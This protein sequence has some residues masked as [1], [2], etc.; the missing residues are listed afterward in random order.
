MKAELLFGLS[1]F[2]LFVPLRCASGSPEENDHLRLN[3]HSIVLL[4]GTGKDQPSGQLKDLKLFNTT[5]SE[6]TVRSKCR[7][8]LNSYAAPC[9][10]TVLKAPSAALTM[11]SS[12]RNRD[13]PGVGF[14]RGRLN[15]PQ[16]HILHSS[17]DCINYADVLIYCVVVAGLDCWYRK[18]WPVDAAGH[19][20][21]CLC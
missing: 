4:H 9:T 15:S 10:T 20:H 21:V 11:Y 14:G 1:H 7:C 18:N 16:A 19:R 2:H 5:L 17:F 12:V 13:A 6:S 8:E 3:P